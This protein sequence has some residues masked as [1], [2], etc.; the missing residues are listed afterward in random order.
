[1]SFK[2][3]TARA[4]LGPVETGTMF[5]VIILPAQ[6]REVEVSVG[7][8]GRY[9]GQLIVRSRVSAE[10]SDNKLQD[11]PSPS[12]SSTVLN[13]NGVKSPRCVPAFA[14]TANPHLVIT[15]LTEQVTAVLTSTRV[16]HLFV[17]GTL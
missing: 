12:R 15:A 4:L 1:M 16:K 11:D 10:S 8:P 17:L 13:K 3:T 14:Y 5:L 7:T 6:P 9:Q 2:G